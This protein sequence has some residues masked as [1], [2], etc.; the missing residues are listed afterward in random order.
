MKNRSGEDIM[1]FVHCTVLYLCMTFKLEWI[2]KKK[3]EIFTGLNKFFC[4]VKVLFE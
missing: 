3:E 4:D 1:Q 2:L